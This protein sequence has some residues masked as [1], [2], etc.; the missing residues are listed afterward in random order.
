[1]A[2]LLWQHAYMWRLRGGWGGGW[3]VIMP[4][5]TQN[6]SFWPA[7]VFHHAIGEV[8]DETVS[9][10]Y[11]EYGGKSSFQHWLRQWRTCAGIKAE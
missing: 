3:G 8:F 5:W 7:L 4:V 9:P 11:F 10:P 1:M 2:T 6:R